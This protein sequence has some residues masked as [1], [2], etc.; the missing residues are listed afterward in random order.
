MEE[1]SSWV[2]R[3][4]HSPTVC[5]RS[6]SSGLPSIP[7]GFQSNQCLEPKGESL[8][9]VL[10]PKDSSSVSSTTSFQHDSNL[11]LRTKTCIPKGIL[12]SV[13]QKDT[14]SGPSFQSD[15]SHCSTPNLKVLNLQNV[16]FSFSSDG[17]SLL[18]S[19]K[20]DSSISCFPSNKEK[21][22]DPVLK[23]DSFSF[24]REV[25]S[26]PKQRS[27]SPLPTNLLSDAF[28]EAR[29]ISRRFSTPP[30]RRK[31]P[32]KDFSRKPATFNERESH[33]P[34]SGKGFTKAKNRRDTS[35]AK[36]FDSG[37]RKVTA[38][39]TTEEWMVDLSQLYFGARFS[40]GAHS[41][42][43]HGVYKD[44]AVAV[45][46]IRLPDDDETG[47]MAARLEKQFTR[48][49]TFLSYLHH[50]NVIKLAG[51]CR[52]PPIFF[53]ITEYL[54]GGSLRVF[55]HKMDHKSLPLDRLVS[56]GLEIARGMEYVHSQGVIHRDLKPENILFDE[57]F[58]VKIADFGVA[59]EELYCDA[60][61][62]DAGTYRWMA[63]EMIKHKRY[64]RKVDVYSFGLLLWEMVTGTVP[65]E[66]MTPIQAAF[67]VVNK[68]MRPIIP[69]DCPVA[70][71]ALIEQCWSSLPEKRPEFS[72]IVKV[73]EHSL[74]YLSFSFSKAHLLASGDRLRRY[75][76]HSRLSTLGERFRS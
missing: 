1:S 3:K 68:N 17:D 32:V 40:C 62:D 44:Q 47:V 69:S 6:R 75:L 20:L 70:L 11:L 64:G 56:I 10:K 42:L 29:T 12:I 22:S 27:V 50:H 8:K 2:T 67:A 76:N 43:Y 13:D 18:N 66:D 24:Q 73:L 21:V 19:M 65:F 55:L 39:E 41:R 15:S 60:L 7:F 74:F 46:V 33:Q 35:W 31:K 63:P 28:K 52:K 58:C 16:D 72:E 48:E 49:T 38:V 57:D 4:K 36:C 61:A 45:K 51:A 37:I 30:P 9:F 59:C 23:S 53:I 71:R 14:K 54:S 26:K 5:Q 34:F 25:K